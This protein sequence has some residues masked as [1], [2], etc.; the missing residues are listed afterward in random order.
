MDNRHDYSTIYCANCGHTV[1]IP[2]RCGLRFCSICSRSAAAR[3]HARISFICNNIKKTKSEGWKLITLTL[4]SSEDLKTMIDSLVTGFRKLRNRRVW[5]ETV[6]GGIYV[7]EITHSTRG[8]HAHLH[9]L[10]MGKFFPQHLLS[11][12]WKA[13]TGSSIVDI[14]QVQP[15][16][17]IGYITHYLTKFD[18]T[19][20]DR[21]DA[22]AAVKNRRLW[23]PFGIA[24]DLNLKYVPAKVPCPHCGALHWVSQW[25][26]DHAM[27]CAPADP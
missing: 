17:A 26:V 19:T 6:R 22:E 27:I 15:G 7:L 23:S 5:K 14:R 2:V 20:G 24:H 12:T 1:Q 10:C 16:G 8:W 9:V 3:A 11:R 4:I 18:L 25:E 21:A 13:I